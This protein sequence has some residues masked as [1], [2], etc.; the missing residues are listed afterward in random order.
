MLIH[1]SILRGF[2]VLGSANIPY[3]NISL[4]VFKK[5]K[6]EN[7]KIFCMG[8]NE[9]KTTNFLDFA[10]DNNYCYPEHFRVGHMFLFK[11]CNYLD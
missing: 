9:V 6:N 7:Y 1:F 10:K 3:I 11:N 8:S 5:M 4:E 2:G